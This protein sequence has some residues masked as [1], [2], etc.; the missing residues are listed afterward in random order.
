MEVE[1]RGMFLV[2]VIFVVLLLPSCFAQCTGYVSVVPANLDA[3]C[4]NLGRV[5]ITCS[6]IGPT[7]I[8]EPQV[9]EDNKMNKFIHILPS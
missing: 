8:K 5:R 7:E 1:Q 2:R 6:Y 4:G 3:V 9:C